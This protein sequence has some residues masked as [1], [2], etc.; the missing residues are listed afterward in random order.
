MLAMTMAMPLA[1][2][3]CKADDEPGGDNANLWEGSLENAPYFEDAACYIITDETSPYESIELTASGL[4][5]ISEGEEKIYENG[6]YYPSFLKKPATRASEKTYLSG[7]FTKQVGG[8]YMLISFGEVKWDK[9][10]NTITVTTGANKVYNWAA[11]QN[12]FVVSNKLNDRLCRTWKIQNA[13]MVFFDEDGNELGNHTFTADQIHEEFVEY[14]TFT[15]SGNAYEYDD[16]DW[17]GYDWRWHNAADQILYLK[18][19]DDSDGEGLCQVSFVNDTMTILQPEY[20]DNYSDA[21]DYV[22][23]GV[24]VPSNTRLIKLYETCVPYTR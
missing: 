24:N 23:M 1:L 14:F 11:K 12:P 16:G 18:G 4:Y 6:G 19:H 22:N 17:Y 10:T 20:L 8:G 5:F 15:R 3:S 13:R 21:W 7:T 2:S 9:D